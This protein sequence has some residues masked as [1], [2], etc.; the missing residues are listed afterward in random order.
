MINSMGRLSL[1]KTKM[2]MLVDLI[3]GTWRR[4]SCVCQTTELKSFEAE[5]HEM[6]SQIKHPNQYK[7]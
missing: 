3:S 2:E 6:G 1:L 4:S 7:H 5:D